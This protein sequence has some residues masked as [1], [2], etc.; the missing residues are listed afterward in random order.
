MTTAMMPRESVTPALVMNDEQVALIKRTIAKNATN[1]ELQLFLNQCKRTGLDPFARQ[2]YFIKRGNQGS[3]QVSIDGFRLIAERAGGYAGQDGPYWC[4]EDGQ[5]KDVWLSKEPPMAAKVGVMRAGFTAPL[6]AVA[7]WKE[8]SQNGPM[9]SKMSALMLAKC[10]ESLALRKA[11]PQELSGLYTT[12][13]MAQA[14]APATGPVLV[15]MAP[16]DVVPEGFE[17]WWLD[18]EVTADNGIEA[19]EKAWAA[20]KPEYKRHAVQQH[21]RAKWDALK[22]KAEH[23]GEAIE[24]SL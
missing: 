15:E 14:D 10:A 13:E 21:G 18:M 6:F 3:I 19:L 5:W 11:F 8:Y 2:I 23:A 20:S 22:I 24:A 1:D 9:W 4:G 16:A 12:D 17:S 7:L